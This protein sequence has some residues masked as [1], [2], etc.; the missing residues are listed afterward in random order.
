MDKN[1]LEK[2]LRNITKEMISLEGRKEVE[3]SFNNF[4]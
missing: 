2:G 3:F 1:S 4:L